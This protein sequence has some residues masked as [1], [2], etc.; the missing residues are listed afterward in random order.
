MP[1]PPIPEWGLLKWANAQYPRPTPL[2]VALVPTPPGPICHL[3]ARQ[4]TSTNT[5][6]P[7]VVCPG[8]PAGCTPWVHPHA[9]PKCHLDARQCTNWDDGNPRLRPVGCTKCQLDALL[10]GPR[11]GH[12]LPS[13]HP[14]DQDGILQ[15]LVLLY[16]GAAGG[17]L[18]VT[19]PRCPLYTTWHSGN[20]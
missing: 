15:A 8:M 12:F 19:G 16:R 1:T 18:L 4:C 7:H 5:T 10:K 6:M 14:Q 11:I 2:V 13:P 17:V 3:D 9:T 20:W